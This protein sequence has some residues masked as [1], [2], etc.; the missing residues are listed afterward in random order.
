MMEDSNEPYYIFQHVVQYIK[1][2]GRASASL[3]MFLDIMKVHMCSV[4][5]F[6]INATTL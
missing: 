1:A 5:V 6:M 3:S 2:A 4:N